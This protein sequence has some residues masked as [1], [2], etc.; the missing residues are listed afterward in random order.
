MRKVANFIEKAFWFFCFIFFIV[1]ISVVLQKPQNN[2]VPSRMS[3]FTIVWLVM[4][5]VCRLIIH[6]LMTKLEKANVNIAKLSNRGIYIYT[7]L[8]GVFIFVIS[9][10]IRNEPVT[11]YQSV[12]DAAWN[13][14]NGFDVTNWEYFARWTNNTSAMTI[15]SFY[16]KLGMGFGLTDPYPFILIINV[17][18]VG[19]SLIST[20]YVA[21]KMSG[22]SYEF[23]WMTVVIYSLWTPI[24]SNTTSFYSDQLS[25]G[26]GIIGFS[27]LLYAIENKKKSGILF[28]LV[29]GAI[30]GL[31]ASIKVTTA[32]PLIAFVIYNLII[33]LRESCTINKILFKM[34]DYV[35]FVIGFVVVLVGI[36]FY[37]DGYPSAN[38][39]YKMQM[40]I[41][42]WLT[43]G[44]NGDGS[45]A[46]NEEFALELMNADNIE[47]RKEMCHDKMQE[48]VPNL[49]DINH[50]TQKVSRIFGSGDISA[51]SIIY[52]YKENLLTE[53]FSE[54]GDYYW[55]YTCLSTSF[56]FAILIWMACG[57]LMQMVNYKVEPIVFWVYVSIFG[58]FLFLLM[59]EAQNKQLYNNLPWVTLAATYGIERLIEY[60]R[61][62]SKQ[63][64]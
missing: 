16:M 44:M 3:L 15:L 24:W 41:E 54:Y 30:I 45:Y 42:Y 36:S 25:F 20:Y 14:A 57:A 1:I 29:A 12:Y 63:S 53:A 21:L 61:V 49:F 28:C 51:T 5:V 11:D 43:I 8:Y 17:L 9:M 6:F 27:L 4:L 7:C 59:W 19:V 26:L 64:K 47:V 56:F 13:L 48:Y 38:M 31:G 33:L 58:L 60:V 37:N 46:A 2:L 55:K 35:L 34:K 50:I 52:P 40:P 18:C 23:T 62:K 10:L 39:E 32:I 22:K